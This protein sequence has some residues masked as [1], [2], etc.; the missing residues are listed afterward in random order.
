LHSLSHLCHITHVTL[1]RFKLKPG[2]SIFEQLVF[3]AKRA[4]I[5]GEFTPGQ[6]FPSVRSLAAELKVHPNTA[7][8]V[9]QHLIQERW[10]EVRPGIGTVVADP[11]E[12]RAGDKRRLLQEELEQ[13]VV[14]AKRVGLALEELVE[15]IE[16]QW[17]RLEKPLEVSRK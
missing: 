9:V 8:R 17:S 6:P 1:L 2:E 14:E 4:F 10:L 12:A 5:S 13:V 15:A 11:P 3:A 7:H 16:F